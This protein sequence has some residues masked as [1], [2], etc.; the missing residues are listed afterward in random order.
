MEPFS[1]MG[2]MV[3]AVGSLAIGVLCSCAKNSKKTVIA[4]W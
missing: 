3:Y 4:T 1:F 2:S